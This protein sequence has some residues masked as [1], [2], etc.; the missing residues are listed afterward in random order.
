MPF[1]FC[2]DELI[3]ILTFIPFIGIFFKRLHAWYHAKFNHKCH[4]ESCSSSHVE[5]HN[6][7]TCGDEHCKTSTNVRYITEEELNKERVK[8]LNYN[9]GP[10]KKDLK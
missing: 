5:H 6:E 10:D 1:H 2:Q 4:E 3:W 8:V 9:F 7:S